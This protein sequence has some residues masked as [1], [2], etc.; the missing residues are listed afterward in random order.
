MWRG[1]LGSEREVWI[2]GKRGVRE[3]LEVRR[4]AEGV[5]LCGNE[6]FH[7][8]GLDGYHEGRRL[9]FSYHSVGF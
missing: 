8:E 6:R 5:R 4:L 9:C 2:E 3:V 1:L 7:D